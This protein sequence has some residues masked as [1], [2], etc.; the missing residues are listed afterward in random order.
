MHGAASDQHAYD[1]KPCEVFTSL[2][3]SRRQ[4]YVETGLRELPSPADANIAVELEA[5]G[6][7][8]SPTNAGRVVE[9]VNDQFRIRTVRGP[10][11]RFES[12][13]P[14]SKGD[15]KKASTVLKKEYEKGTR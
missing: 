4:G 11:S 10:E 7:I 5:P 13:D 1:A 14:S 9:R 3:C 2:D 12:I 6:Y 15:W 8:R